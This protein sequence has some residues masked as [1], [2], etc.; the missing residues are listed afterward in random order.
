MT[1]L[2]D[3]VCNL[4]N[5]F[6][7]FVIKRDR[8]E[9]FTFGTLQSRK[10]QELLKQ[11]G[12]GEGYLATVVVI[13]GQHAFVESDAVLMIAR[14]LGGWWKALLVFTLVPTSIRDALYRTVARHRYRLF[15]R[16]ETCMTPTAELMHRFLDRGA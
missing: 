8:R 16:R 3:G 4:C 9:V 7:Q 13:E 12:F 11:T 15:G 6:V 2:F 14:N 5:G 1:I 10:A